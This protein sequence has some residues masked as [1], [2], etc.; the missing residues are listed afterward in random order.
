M[1]R[2]PLSLQLALTLAM[3]GP[4]L[5]GCGGGELGPADEAEGS[6]AAELNIVDPVIIASDAVCAT[7]EP[8]EPDPSSWGMTEDGRFVHPAMTPHQHE[9]RPFEGQLD[10]WDDKDYIHNM[11]VESYVPIVVE[12]FHTWQNIVDFDGAAISISMFGAR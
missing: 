3:T 9:P 5:A 7:N 2:S 11:K 10:Y 8:P 1:T 4:L 12:P 6:H